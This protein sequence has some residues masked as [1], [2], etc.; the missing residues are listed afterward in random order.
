MNIHIYRGGRYTMF[1]LAAFL[2]YAFVMTFTPGPNNIMAMANAGKYG[3]KKTLEFNAGVFAGFLVILLFSTYFNLFLFNIMPKV[4]VFMGILGAVYML[5]LAIHIMKSKEENNESKES[6]DD[7]KGIKLNLFFTG[8]SLQV[9]NPKCILYSITV[10]SNFIIPYYKSNTA[11]IL[12]SLFLG[13]LCFL[14]TTSWALFGSLFNK[15]LFKYR[16]QFNVAMGLLLI[17]SAI[18]ISGII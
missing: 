10:M 4:K 2:S 5:Y 7:N 18:S 8:M 17:Y 9:V 16:K 3:L 11:L 1:N 14:S 13:F 12:F 15:F 6:S